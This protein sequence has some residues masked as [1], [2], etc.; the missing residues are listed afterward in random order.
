MNTRSFRSSLSAPLWVAR[1]AVFAALAASAS[2]APRCV[3]A[4][5][6]AQPA[7]RAPA[8]E[9][10]ARAI[11]RIVGV[12]DDQTGTPI[13]SVEVRDMASGSTALTTSTGTLS[14]FFV[15]TAGS[16]IRFRKI[17]FKPVTMFVAN[18]P[19][20]DP[21]TVVLERAAQTLEKVVVTDNAA[22][23]HSPALRGFE[24]RRKTGMGYFISE[25]QMR[26]EDNRPLSQVVRAHVPAVSIIERRSGSKWVSVALSRRLDNCL[27]DIYLD[28]VQVSG[29]SGGGGSATVGSRASSVRSGDADLRSFEVSDLAAV[30]F[31]N[32]ADMP[33]EFGHTGS[34]CGALFLWTRE[35]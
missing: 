16:L 5:A 6:P 29:T 28:G 9:P 4:Q 24:E 1:L 22:V 34:G 8:T 33:I 35:R 20:I 17:G 14:L 30:E 32:V 11:G 21:L 18:A 10:A 12:Y 25:S 19:G 13:D 3:L 15:D 31:H 23:Y 26:K 7:S 2:A 27:V